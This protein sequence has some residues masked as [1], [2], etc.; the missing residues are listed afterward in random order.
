MPL[1]I[2]MRTLHGVLVAGKW[3]TEPESA[4]D[5]EW[6][7]NGLISK[8]H[9]YVKP[10]SVN[11][12][13]F[14][15]DD[16]IAHAAIVIFLM[17]EAGYT[18]A[19]LK[20]MTPDS[21]RMAKLYNDMTL[22]GVLVAGKWTTEPESKAT[23]DAWRNHLIW[24][25]NQYTQIEPTFNYQAFQNP[26]LIDSGAIVVFLLA[27]GWSIDQLKLRTD[28]DHR[29]EIIIWNGAHTG[30]PFLQGLTNRQLVRLAIA[31]YTATT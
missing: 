10:G 21:Q 24:I 1:S 11:Y 9:E 29:N 5:Q 3:T 28:D 7:R 8:L 13:A 23:S 27:V 16:L 20:T 6:W 12:Q 4:H 14:Q 15:N 31:E 25:L 18:Q 30:V 2:D 19:R 17:Q 22:H 26:A